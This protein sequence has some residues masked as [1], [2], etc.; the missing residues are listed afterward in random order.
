MLA[1]L[2]A[3]VNELDYLHASRRWG[4]AGQ[5]RGLKQQRGSAAS[6]FSAEFT[7]YFH[8]DFTNSSLQ[9]LK[10]NVER[11]TE[12]IQGPPGTIVALQYYYYR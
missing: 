6:S 4:I 2:F 12:R 8:N 7:L 3:Q 5:Y 11:Q 1:P 10:L 9:W